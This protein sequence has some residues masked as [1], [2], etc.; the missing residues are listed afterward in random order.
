ML[1][2]LAVFLAVLSVA[3][4]KEQPAPIAPAS[5]MT[6]TSIPTP[7]NLRVEAI[8]A[9]SVRLAWDAV[10]GVDDYDV[11]YKEIEGSWQVVPHHGTETYNDID[12]LM[13]NTN[14]QWTVKADRESETSG[15][16]YGP[17]FTTLEGSPELLA[18]LQFNITLIFDDKMPENE[19]LW[20][21]QMADMWEEVIIG[22]LP[23]ET[24]PEEW[25][26]SKYPDMSGTLEAV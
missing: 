5:K 3:C 16:K 20:F 22:D 19:R 6:T 12:G 24:I 18:S 23:D 13:P 9:Q 21:R 14:Y 26:Y 2:A 17:S 4:S 1:R 7:T 11:L 8:T 10:E 15:W 25:N